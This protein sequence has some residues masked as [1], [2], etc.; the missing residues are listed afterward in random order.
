MAHR[1]G[2]EVIIEVTTV[3]LMVWSI[4]HRIL[5]FRDLDQVGGPPRW[6][7]VEYGL[8]DSGVLRNDERVV[9]DQ[10]CLYRIV[11]AGPPYRYKFIK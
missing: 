5:Y 6:R 7:P 1:C 11:D 4:F 9:R 2:H 8:D 10:C 3:L